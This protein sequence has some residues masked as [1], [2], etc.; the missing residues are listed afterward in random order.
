MIALQ[1]TLIPEID[2]KIV[3]LHWKGSKSL[4]TDRKPANLREKKKKLPGQ[5][6]K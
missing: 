5:P 3:L 1:D 4:W 6:D 2:E